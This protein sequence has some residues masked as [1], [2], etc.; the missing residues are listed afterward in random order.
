MI[1][2][3]EEMPNELDILVNPSAFPKELELE[4][5]E[6]FHISYIVDTDQDQK[7][8][9]DTKKIIEWINQLYESSNKQLL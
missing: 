7:L 1:F 3:M 8:I 6:P 4:N 5:T 9:P 2:K